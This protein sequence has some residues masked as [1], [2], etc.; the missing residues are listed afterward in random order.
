MDHRQR[1]LENFFIF[2]KNN[3]LHLLPKRKGKV[4]SP[5]TPD[6]HRPKPNGKVVTCHNGARQTSGFWVSEDLAYYLTLFR[7]N[8]DRVLNPVRVVAIEF[9]RGV[10][11]LRRETNIHK[12]IAS[13]FLS[14]L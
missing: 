9:L 7:N 3:F 12:G 1:N 14:S 4:T 13:R 2:S 11:S 6:L 10:A 8:S 5:P